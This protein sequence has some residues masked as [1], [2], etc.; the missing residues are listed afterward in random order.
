MLRKTGIALLLALVCFGAVHAQLPEGFEVDVNVE[1]N[2]VELKKTEKSDVE[3]R[4]EAAADTGQTIAWP[5][6]GHNWYGNTNLSLSY[7]GGFFGGKLSLG[8]TTSSEKYYDKDK[9]EWFDLYPVHAGAMNAWVKLFNDRVKVSLGRGIGSGYADTQGGEALRIFTGVDRDTWDKS[10]APDDIV[11]DEGLLLQGFFGPVSIGLAGRYYTPSLFTKNLNAN[12][13]VDEKK[14]TRFASM[15][16]RNFSYGARIGSEIGEWGK[17]NAA[18]ILEY[19]NVTGDNYTEDR[20]GKLVPKT[21]EAEFARHLFGVFA[22]L[23]PLDKL[24][25]SLGYNGVISKYPDQIYGLQQMFNVTMPMVFQQGVN[26]NLRYG[27][28]GPWVFRTD[29]NVSFWGDKNFKIFNFPGLEDAGITAESALNLAYPV[30]DHLLIWNGLGLSCQ[31]S[32]VWKLELYVRNL[33]R[34]DLAKDAAKDIEYL[35]TRNQI[36]GELKGC[37]QAKDNIEAYIG[38]E[39][40]NTLTIISKDA[41][42][43]TVGIKD[44]FTVP[45]NVKEIRDTSLKI[46]VPVGLTVRMR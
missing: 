14:N 15:E 4:K 45:A 1:T 30:V 43:E 19:D 9:R 46:K 5:F 32:A 27:G 34:R 23:S 21:G 10:R 36:K 28:L 12:D 38:V 41:A 37:W 44:G 17:I 31:P 8:V 33:Y 39:I 26:L 7:D 29:H 11:Q 6:G 16:Q 13:P 35:F 40:E 42:K 3:L 20:D 24:G 22:S 25:V 18:Y 2:A